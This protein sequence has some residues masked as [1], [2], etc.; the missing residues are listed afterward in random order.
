MA[1]RISQSEA[2][3]LSLTAPAKGK[4]GPKDRLRFVHDHAER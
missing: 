3:R 1:A 4:R 2:R